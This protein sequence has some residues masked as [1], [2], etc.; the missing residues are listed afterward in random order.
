MS[1]EKSPDKNDENLIV[2]SPKIE[3][4]EKLGTEI[5]ENQNKIRLSIK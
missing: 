1:T 4:E 5:E 3:E 2:A